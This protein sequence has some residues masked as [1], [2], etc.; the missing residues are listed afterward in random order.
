DALVSLDRDSVMIHRKLVLQADRPLSNTRV[1]LPDGEEFVSITAPTGPALKWKRVQQTLELRWQEPIPLNVGASM[2]LVSRKKLAKAWSGQGI[3]EKVL[4]ENL[5]VPEAVKV[6]GYTALAFD[7]AWRVRLGVLSGLEDRDVKYS[8]VTGGRM[9]W[10]GLR[11][12]S[13]NFEVERAESVYAAVITAYALPRARTVEIEGQ[14]GLEISGAPLREFKIK[15]PP[16]VAALLRVTSPSVGEQK[17]DEASGVWTC[18]LIR[19]STGQQNIRFRISLPAEV[20]GIESETTVKTI[21]AVLPRLE[22]P[23]ARRFRGTWVIEANTDTQLSFVAKSLQPLDVLRAPAVDGYAPRHRVVGAYTYGTTEHELKLT[24]ERHA[25]SEL[26]ALI[27]M[28]LQMTT[29]LGND[30]NA[31]HSA[32]LNLRHSGEQ[33]VTLDLPEGAELLSTVV[34]G[35]AVKPVRSQGSAIAIPLPGDSANQPNVAVRIQ[36][37]LPA[38]AWTGSGA[39]KMQPVRLPGSVPILSTSWGIDVPEGYTY[40]K[41]ETRLEASGF[42][43]MGTLGESLKAWLESLTWPLG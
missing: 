24:A 12:W 11:D 5:R 41:P 36:Y 9:A 15:L 27:V 40:A 38:A 4:V 37:Q 28:Q 2:T 43:A 17:L 18:T 42:D 7:D 13:L 20:S 3:A 8:P 29:V 1:T 14:V 34:N 39:L 21:T 30:G 32:L 33:F 6:T 35:A 25:H 10:F 22:M 26:A 23:E 19:E 16:A 31:L